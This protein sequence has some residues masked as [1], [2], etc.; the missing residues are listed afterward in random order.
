MTQTTNNKP[1]AKVRSG[2][3]EAA[4]WA[5][6][7]TEGEGVRYSITYVRSYKDGDQWKETNSFSEIDSLKLARLIGKA[8]DQLDQLKS[9]AT[10]TLEE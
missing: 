4:I 7:R 6:P 9:R 3:I 2:S 8:L 5:N 1:A 10:T